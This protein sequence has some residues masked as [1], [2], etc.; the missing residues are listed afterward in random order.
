MDVVFTVAQETASRFHKRAGERPMSSAVTTD[1]AALL[2]RLWLLNHK[3]GLDDAGNVASTVAAIEQQVEDMVDY[4]LHRCSPPSLSTLSL[5]VRCDNLR[6]T[7][8]QQA[9][10][11][12]VKKE[13]IA[14]Q[15]EEALL[16]MEPGMVTAEQV[17]GSLAVSLI[18]HYGS[19]STFLGPSFTTTTATAATASKP[20]T[21]TQASSNNNPAYGEAVS[22]VSAAL[23]AAQMSAFLRQDRVERAGQLRQLRRIAWGLR[24][25]QKE[26][27]R[28][29]GMDMAPLSTTVDA[30][31][32]A[33]EQ[34]CED[35]LTALDARIQP[36]RALLTS[37]TCAL[38]A[39]DQ[40]VLREEYHH[41]LL[42]LHML[43]C[44]QCGLRQ[45][46]DCVSGRVMRSYQTTLSELRELLAP[47]RKAP[48]ATTNTNATGSHGGVAAPS[49]AVPKK[50]V[51]PLFME[52][53]DAYELGM[54]CA[55]EYSHYASLLQIVAES[56]V[57]YSSTLPSAAA[58]D[59]L[60]RE[61]AAAAASSS[62]SDAASTRAALMAE[63]SAILDSDTT[64]QRLPR[65]V[66]V[67]YCAELPL[68]TVDAVVAALYPQSL[69]AMRGCC[70]VQYL[71]GRPVSG[72]LLPGQL[73]VRAHEP[74]LKGEGSDPSTAADDAAPA[75]GDAS[76][77][78]VEVSGGVGACALQRPLRFVF[79]DTAAMRIFAADPWRYV[80]GCLRVF[81]ADE[82][83]ISLVMG[84]ADELPRELY[85]EGA[86]TVERVSGVDSNTQS[87]HDRADCATQTGQIDSFID[88]HYFWNEW[89]L[90]RHALKLA[91]LMQMRTHSSQT[92]ASHFRREATTQ[93]NPPKDAE[94]QTL[95][96]AATQPPHVV[97]Y[98]KGLRGTE[99]SSVEQVQHVVEY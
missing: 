51:F 62:S 99:T 32:T 17:W 86:R 91:N 79:A 85:L 46:R 64:R 42:M 25:Y 82:P 3:M 38:A 5:Q 31:L 80:H 68:H 92:A 73:Q 16:S 67:R 9:Q 50:V 47:T 81:H 59:A 7:H 23:P 15:L 28:S 39:K 55:A 65:D 98:L 6:I 84:L 34:R 22:A 97:Q 40:A 56:A 29:A 13:S 69:C 93:V 87:S 30:P 44:A 12:A 89:D 20:T 19:D 71:Q 27:G 45:L 48:A 10:Q 36:T 66:H 61:T 33:L 4:L 49:E 72:L 94:T 63:V 78:C 41:L 60:A 2:T 52:L 21:A 75:P 37:P 57:G 95:K 11:A 18:H 53:A 58:E 76:L 8:A 74:S 26:S 77:G 35:A 24:L 43:K 14:M 54:K 1:L 70:P 88:H 96:D 83:T 90:R